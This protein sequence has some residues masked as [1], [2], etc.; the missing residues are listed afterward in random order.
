MHSPVRRTKVNTQPKNGHVKLS[1][2][3]R[4]LPRIWRLLSKR[5]HPREQ[6]EMTIYQVTDRL[7]RGRMAYVPEDRIV[8]TVSA[9]LAE[10]GVESPFVDELA[11]TVHAGNWPAAHGIADY[12]SVEI[13]L[14]A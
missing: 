4:Q 1:Q 8:A 12:L 11:R 2:P 3:S 7:H 5:S 10:V 9:W 6:E 13:A 14:V